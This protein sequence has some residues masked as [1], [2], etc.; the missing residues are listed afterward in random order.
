M[1]NAA[2]DLPSQSHETRQSQLRHLL[3]LCFSLDEIRT[4]AFDIGVDFD[5]LSG[6][7]KTAKIRELILFSERRNILDALI[8]AAAGARPDIF[9]PSYASSAAGCPYRGLSPFSEQD[10]P[11]FFGRERS[12]DQ[13]A[14]AINQSELLALFGSSGNGKSSVVLAGLLPRLRREGHWITVY[15]RPGREPFKELAR[16]LIPL[17]E[18]EMSEMDRLLEIGELNK[19]FK[20]KTVAL[21]DILGSILQGSNRE[22]TLLLVV[23]QLEEL[24]AEGID[25][26]T[27]KQF[28]D[29]LVTVTDRSWS[30]QRRDTPAKVL[31]VLRSD[32]MAP[33]LEYQPLA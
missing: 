26:S 3:G 17:L 21:I 30:R 6:E 15:C 2:S 1:R 10:G 16:A 11:Y 22:T 8:A 23:D 27:R 14:S 31:L 9:W 25:D 4:L 7:S 5:E 19:A 24:Y 20:L 28:F 18:A 33:A 29:C 32:V 13:L 12:V